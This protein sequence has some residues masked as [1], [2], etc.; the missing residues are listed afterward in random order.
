MDPGFLGGLAAVNFHPDAV[1]WEQR[2][3]ANGGTVSPSTMKAVSDLTI[4]INA[5]SGLR[6]SITRLNLF[7]GDNINACFVP[8]YLAEASGAAAKGNVTD[9]NNNFDS[10]D[11]VESGP[12]GGLTSNGVS[13]FLRTGL[14]Q[15]A[16]SST[17]CHLS[18]SLAGITNSNTCLYL[19]CAFN[20][21]AGLNDMG[22]VDTG[23]SNFQALHRLGSLVL[24]NPV[25][26]FAGTETHLI[27][28]RTSSN[29]AVMYRSGVAVNTQTSPQSATF[30][31]APYSIFAS[32]TNES[33]TTAGAFTAGRG[34]MYSI[35]AGLTAAQSL[36]FSVAVAQFNS[37]LGRG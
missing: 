13:K 37:A 29:N 27:S 26:P 11:Y 21:P 6:A 28:T 2:V 25:A 9:L 17:S 16:V 5:Q 12:N 36:A 22:R 8:L 19:G 3:L 18:I 31:N 34:R 23:G 15:N 1:S 10:G 4:A 35:G 24:N 7:C 32:T 20:F 33:G 14:P 30:S